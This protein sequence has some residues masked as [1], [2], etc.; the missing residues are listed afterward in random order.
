MVRVKIQLGLSDNADKVVWRYP[1]DS[2]YEHL[3]HFINETFDSVSNG[4]SFQIQ[5]KDDEGD[6][7]T[8]SSESDINDALNFAKSEKLKSLKLF[9]VTD[10]DDD[11]TE[12][13]NGKLLNVSG[14]A[15]NNSEPNEDDE[16]DEDDDDD[17]DEEENDA[18][19]RTLKIY[20]SQLE[21]TQRGV[22]TP[23]KE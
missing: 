14:D 7:I 19:R 5:Y 4:P 11:D 22:G 1:D 16:A 13:Q 18:E 2:R 10:A 20:I 21:A 15:I 6:L 3:L 17:D 12:N 9:I 8:C 23:F